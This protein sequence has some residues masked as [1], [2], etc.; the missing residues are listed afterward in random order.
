MSGGIPTYDYHKPISQAHFLELIRYWPEELA[1]RIKWFG[2][3]RV[4]VKAERQ[5]PNEADL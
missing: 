5:V 4:R 2:K 3:P 1:S